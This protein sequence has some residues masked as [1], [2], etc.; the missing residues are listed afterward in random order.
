MEEDVREMFFP[1]SRVWR[2]EVIRQA[3]E[4]LFNTLRLTEARP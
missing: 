3:R 2:S 4:T 1:V